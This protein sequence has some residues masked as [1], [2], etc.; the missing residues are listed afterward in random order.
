MVTEHIHQNDLVHSGTVLLLHGGC[1]RGLSDG[2]SVIASPSVSQSCIDFQ[3][4]FTGKSGGVL[5]QNINTILNFTA[6][7]NVIV[8]KEVTEAVLRGGYI[9]DKGHI[10]V[11]TKHIQ[12][13]NLG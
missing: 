9:L 13:H 3:F 12:G 10:D 6:T 4:N 2:L 1:S 8:G 11:G 5:S 7:F